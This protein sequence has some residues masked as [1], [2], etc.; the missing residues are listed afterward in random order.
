M[1]LIEEVKNEKYTMYKIEGSQMMKVYADHE[2]NEYTLAYGKVA[3]ERN[4]TAEK[5]EIE[6]I[7][8]A[9]WVDIIIETGLAIKNWMENNKE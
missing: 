5:E 1:K 3:I 2:K 7:L 4:G 8:N 6:G 9:R